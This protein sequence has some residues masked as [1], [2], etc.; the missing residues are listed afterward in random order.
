MLLHYVTLYYIIV[1]LLFGKMDKMGSA[2]MRSLQSSWFLTERLFGYQSVKICQFCVPLFPNPSK[3]VTSSAASPL[4][5]TPFVRSQRHCEPVRL[6]AGED[7]RTTKSQ[8]QA[9]SI[10]LSLYIYI[11][12]LIMQIIIIIIIIT[13]T[14]VIVI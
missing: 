2:L 6:T 10:Y 14:I 8:Q 5:P 4:V 1:Y 3:F 9:I 11:Y 7:F 12:K 13:I